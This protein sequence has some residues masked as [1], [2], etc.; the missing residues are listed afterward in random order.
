MTVPES[1]AW[2][3]G[4]DAKIARARELL[5][6]FSKEANS[7]NDRIERITIPITNESSSWL[8]HYVQNPIPPVRLSVLMGD[9]LYNLRSA[10]DN[11]VCGLIRVQL[12]TSTCKDSQFPICTDPSHWNRWHNKDL[13]G[14]E[15][16]A[17][18]LI[19]EMQPCFCASASP[20]SHPLAI[21]NEL[22][23][24]DKHRS[25]NFTL[26]FTSDLSFTVHP[27]GGSPC[28]VKFSKPQYAGDPI[29]IPLDIA[30]NLM[31]PT[32]RVQL[33]GT[34][35]LL[36]QSTDPWNTQPVGQLLEMLF[37]HV[38]DRV[39]VPLKP[40]FIPPLPSPTSN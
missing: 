15:P 19:R 35:F 33:S 25:S 1:L 23:N 26:N 24:R 27:N 6:E 31:T 22:C 12:S 29:T 7:Y 39:V 13:K 10:L 9:F 38:T 5:D 34:T 37:S 4:V 18:Q 16:A 28:T 21:L 30:P 8:V 36:L 17:M 40:F 2:M 20:A 3:E 11:L 32:V 14:I